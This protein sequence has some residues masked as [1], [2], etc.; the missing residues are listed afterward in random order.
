M[1]ALPNQMETD[2]V[3]PVDRSRADVPSNLAAATARRLCG[4][5]ADCET[6]A[7]QTTEL[8]PLRDD[9]AGCKDRV[10][11]TATDCEA[12]IL[13]LSPLGE[14]FVLTPMAT[15]WPTLGGGE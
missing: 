4:S 2:D 12:C 8:Q 15:E 6:V 10:G 9:N 11:G 14:A 13:L 5:T 1:R 3:A 7:A